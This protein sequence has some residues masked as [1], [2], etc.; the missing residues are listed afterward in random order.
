MRAEQKIGSAAVAHLGPEYGSLNQRALDALEDLV[1]HVRNRA[2]SANVVLDLS[3]TRYFGA[4]FIGVLVRATIELRRCGRRL[5]LSGL[6]PSL[7]RVLR[8]CKLDTVFARSPDMASA[9]EWSVGLRDT[10]STEARVDG[11]GPSPVRKEE[12]NETPSARRSGRGGAAQCRGKNQ[13][14]DR[15]SRYSQ[16]E[17]QTG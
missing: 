7:A 4:G 10:T 11:T 2:G 15:A 5:A 12:T 6:R 3:E 13:R 17:T 9:K 14:R 16:R 1:R 8:A